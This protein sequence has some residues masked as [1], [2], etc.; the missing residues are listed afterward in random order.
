MSE[1]PYQ[2]DGQEAV[3]TRTGQDAKPSRKHKSQVVESHGQ[4][5]DTVG[6]KQLVDL[7]PMD[8]PNP[9]AV[10][11]AC[12]YRGDV[13]TKP[14]T[15]SLKNPAVDTDSHRSPETNQFSFL[16]KHPSYKLSSI[17]SFSRKQQRHG[18]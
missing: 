2:S 17:K 5:W 8:V 15:C 10:V 11:S 13:H 3:T 18:L 1:G 16:V 4:T 7:F 14:R 9:K 12:E 6:L